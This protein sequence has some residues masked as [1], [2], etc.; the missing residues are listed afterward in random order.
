M[1]FRKCVAEAIGTFALIFCGTGAVIINQETNGVI[2]HPGVAITFGLLVMCLIY[3]L[4]NI[5][6]C[7]INPA[8]TIAFTIARKFKIKDVVPYIISQLAGAFI[9][10]IF[11]KFLFPL[12]SIR[13]YYSSWNTIAI[14]YP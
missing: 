10:S 1:L 5:S 8:V 6:G 7:H 11:L 2:T 13:C 14:I 9:G 3:T 12:N 4:G